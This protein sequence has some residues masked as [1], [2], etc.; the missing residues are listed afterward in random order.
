MINGINSIFE[1]WK[2]SLLE[3]KIGSIF[4]VTY[5]PTILMNL[6]NQATSYIHGE[7]KCSLVITVN[8]YATLT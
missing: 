2:P 3:R 6:I 7:D 1:V 5:L 4:M 8:M